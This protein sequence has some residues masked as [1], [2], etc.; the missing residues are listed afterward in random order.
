MHGL[1]LL[2]ALVA[3]L[4]GG[5]FWLGGK[6]TPGTVEQAA[7]QTPAVPRALAPEAELSSTDG[8]DSKVERAAQPAPAV[9]LEGGAAAKEAAGLSGRVVGP[10]GRP[11]QGAKVFA[12]PAGDFNF[13]PLDTVDQR[14]MTGAKRS[15]AVTDAEGRFQLGLGGET[16]V[17]LAVRASGFAPLDAERTLARGERDLG[18]VALEQGVVLEGR[19]IDQTGRPVAEAQIHSRPRSAGFTMEMAGVRGRPPLATTDAGGRFRID[20]LASGPWRML[21]SSEEHPDKTFDG[22]SERPGAVTRNLE[23]ALEEGAQIAGRVTGAPA[24]ALAKLQVNA[25]QRAEND[26]SG[27]DGIVFG[28]G[29]FTLPRKAK[30]GADGSFVVRGL[31]PN[32]SYRLDAQKSDSGFFGFGTVSRNGVSAKSGDRG[33]EVP[34]KVASAI[35]CQVVDAATGKPVTEMDVKAGYGWSIPLMDADGK[36]KNTFPE[37]NVRFDRL[38][39]RFGDGRG[40]GLKLRI[41]ATGYKSYESPELKLVQGQDLDLGVVRLERAPVCRVQVLDLATGQGL[42]GAE[43]TL[44][45]NGADQN[46]MLG[47]RSVRIGRG[48]RTVNDAGQSQGTTGADGNVVLSSFPG[49]QAT[50]KVKHGDYAVWQNASIALAADGDHQ[51]TVKLARG[52]EVLVTV[53]DAKGQ[54][55]AGVEIEHATD[56]GEPENPWMRRMSGEGQSRTDAR[57]ELVFAHL[58]SGAHR[59]RV[60]GDGGMGGVFATPGGGGAIRMAFGT[61]ANDAQQPQEEPWTSVDV[62][63]GGHVPVKLVAPARASVVGRVREGGQALAGASVRL[64]EQHEGAQGSMSMPFFGGQDGPRTNGS[65]EYK[66]EG[67]KPGKYT[68]HVTHPARAMG[69]EGELEVG[70]G[71]LR[72][73][74][75]LPIAIVEGRVTG[76]DGKPIAG[77]RVSVERAQAE[78]RQTQMVFSVAIAGDSGDVMSFGGSGGAEPVRTDAD[79]RYTL[80]GLLTGTDL[81]VHVTGKEFT[82]A[83]S[84]KFRVAPDQTLRGIDVH[85]KQGGNL[86]V[87]ITR[88]GQPAGGVLVNAYHKSK[89]G[90]ENQQSDVS[91][92]GGVAR[93]SGLEPGEWE[94]SVTDLSATDGNAPPES[95]RKPVKIAPGETSKADHELH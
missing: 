2:L 22:E 6:R 91:G 61:N 11:V 72:Y 45:E 40:N 73:D 93:F 15:D 56:S 59:F 50:L 27:G 14:L 84:E 16:H 1:I 46:G 24:D 55:V 28:P 30:V 48:G 8:A 53:A 79:G 92:A 19:V 12:G 33:I 10:D 34:Y 83:N 32:Q 20:M 87:R 90:S 41:D 36:A 66:C 74:I 81:V 68:V 69:W 39:P 5:L 78:T 82:P 63:E 95:E 21:V 3:L 70:E 52:G 29:G 35:V 4:V 67:V 25:Q 77:A 26:E 88:A 44:R 64:E 75:E 13:L 54:P 7:A 42:A 38:P 65:G 31:K 76:P 51:E 86:E 23:F 89:D 17:R 57:G 37:G 58:E 60:A 43:V 47:V 94:Y 18:D 49:K 80:R 62:V 71:E 85:P 9:R